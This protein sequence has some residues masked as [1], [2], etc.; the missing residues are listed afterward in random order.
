MQPMKSRTVL[1]SAIG[2]VLAAA[3]L[4]AREA[5]AAEAAETTSLLK[6][7]T[8]TARKREESLQLVPVSV[9][10]V[11]AEDL[12]VQSLNS[13]KEVA[14]FTPNFTISNQG[15]AGSSVG[16][17]YIRGIGQ[18]DPLPTNEPGVG[19]YLD[20]VYYGRMQ[21]I[22]LDMM[23]LERIE[24]LRGPQGTLF[25]KNTIGGAVSIVSAKPADEFQGRVKLTAGRYERRDA[26]ASVNLPLVADRLALRVAGSSRHSDGFGHD[27][28]GADMGSIDN[29]SGRA[30]LLATPSDSFELLLALDVTK[31]RENGPVRDVLAI[32]TRPASGIIGLLNALRG[33]NGLPPYDDRWVNEDPFNSFATEGNLS[34]NDLH[35][36]SLTATWSWDSYALKSI[37]A[38]RD[39]DTYYCVDPDGS[40]VTIIDQCISTTHHQFSQEFQLNGQSFDDRL[41]W[42][43]GLF[44]F[45][46]QAHTWGD[47]F[48]ITD[49]FTLPR[50]TPPLPP[51]IDITFSNDIRIDNESYAAYAQ[52]TYALSD[53]LGLTAGLRYTSEDKQ[54]EI[55]RN[56]IFTP[57]VII[58]F[59]QNSK[60]WDKLSPRLGLD[61]RWTPEIMTYVSV[62]QGYKAGGFN[63]QASRNDAFTAY[64]AETAWT[65]EAGLRSDLLDGRLRFNVTAFY[66]Q[67]EDIQ[68][69]VIQGNAQGEPISTVQNAGK[70]E[71]KGGEIELVA[72]PAEGWTFNAAVGLTDANYT[73]VNPEVTAGSGVTTDSHFIKTPKWSLTLSGQYE[74]P[75]SERLGLLA[76][77]DYA[78]KS[79][80][81]HDA[82]NSPLIVQSA[83]PLLNARLGLKE[84]DGGWSLAVFGT[85]LTDEH[86]IVAGTD[87]RTSLGFAEVQYA[88]PREWGVSVEYTW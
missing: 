10:A 44:Y 72:V 17:V 41:S 20:G 68:F 27:G 84:R 16:L 55:F 2:V 76:R 61:F 70:A 47:I 34:E 32:P 1:G 22:D 13:L 83:Y 6:E 45:T 71:I 37:T 31:V 49:V 42:V 67:Y 48:V 79:K 12:E 46:E 35:G 26:V 88:R 14:Q 65:Y 56:R 5:R 21:G 69:T 15:Q 4:P 62:A 75:V 9:T 86:Y 51:P 11:S 33:L 53:R 85:N 7:I 54:G 58:P 80:I 60:S 43:A 78:Y 59:T 66:S 36:A 57:G 38:Y 50:P 77:V 28:N 73:R 19:I 3:L 82:A 24:I 63:G 30:T 40:P 25:G 87:F 39:S 29:L 52:G 74:R 18:S 81:Y 23:D 64:D 8:V